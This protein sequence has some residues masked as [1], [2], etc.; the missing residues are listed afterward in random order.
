MS[1]NT[2]DQQQIYNEQQIIYWL[3]QICS[4][5]YTQYQQHKF[6]EVKRASWR[7]T[8]ALKPSRRKSNR[9][10]PMDIDNDISHMQS[11]H[12]QPR[13]SQTQYNPSYTTD[14]LHIQP[15]HVA[16]QFNDNINETK[17]QQQHSKSNCVI[18]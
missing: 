13:F 2:T 12:Q 16:T 8:D 9:Y 15:P 14:A 11:Y 10:E 4:K 18:C 1:D 17:Q 6:G 3:E 7:W 5:L